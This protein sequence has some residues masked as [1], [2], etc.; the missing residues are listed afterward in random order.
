LK[1]RPSSS[2][3]TYPR[4]VSLDVLPWKRHIYTLYMTSILVLIRSIFRVVEYI[5]GEDG[6]LLSKEI[7]LYVFDALLMLAVMVLFNWIHPSQI[8]HLYMERIG[9]ENVSAVAELQTVR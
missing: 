4:S 1:N 6:Y 9:E 8:M 2:T 3:Y 5:Q 7:Y